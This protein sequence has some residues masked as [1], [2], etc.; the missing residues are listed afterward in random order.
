MKCIQIRKTVYDE[1]AEF[2]IP[3]TK[4]VKLVVENATVTNQVDD[5]NYDSI[6]INMHDNVFEKMKLCK[7]SPSESHS[8]TLAR[9]INEYREK[10]SD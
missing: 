5:G 3:I 6:N 4:A 7:Q 8:D 1:L 10:I 9:L 2:D